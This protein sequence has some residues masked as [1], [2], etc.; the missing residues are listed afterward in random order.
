MAKSVYTDLSKR[1]VISIFVSLLIIFSI[2]FSLDPHWK[3]FHL[4]LLVVLGFFATNEYVEMARKK[5]GFI[6]SY[7]PQISTSIL[8][9]FMFIAAQSI[10][11]TNLIIFLIFIYLLLNFFL[12][13]G[14]KKSAIYDLAVSFFPIIYIALP[15]GL[16]FFVLFGVPHGR[17][18][19]AY[20]IF[21]TK[22]ADIGAYFGGKAFGRKKLAPIISPNKT[23]AG[24]ICAILVAVATSLVAYTFAYPYVEWG[25]EKTIALGLL[26]GSLGQCGDL[27]ESLLK[28][29]AKIK[30]SSSLPGIGG[31]LDLLDSIL[32]NIPVLFFFLLWFL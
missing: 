7:V 9:I 22:V 16:S 13:L 11:R 3:Y 29:D 26:L 15:L 17:W 28:R 30:D 18:W 27:F 2:Y 24:F 21:V 5:G 25:W 23:V 14:F 12:H 1:L 19:I 8:V 10:A 31:I 6:P 20:L 4:S 32:L